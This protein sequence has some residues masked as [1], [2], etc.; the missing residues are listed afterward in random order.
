[1]VSLRFF[2]ALLLL[3][4]DQTIV[5]EQH[6]FCFWGTYEEKLACCYL[7]TLRWQLGSRQHRRQHSS[8]TMVENQFDIREKQ[9]KRELA[10]L[11][12]SG[13]VAFIRKPRPGFYKLRVAKDN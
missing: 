3:A 11:T 10:G 13:L 1:M 6:L 8:S 12:N 7:Q 4:I 9:A 2:Q 5:L